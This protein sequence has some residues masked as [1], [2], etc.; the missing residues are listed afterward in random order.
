[1]CLV[2]IH[3]K[4]INFST[5]QIYF[6]IQQLFKII[7]IIISKSSTQHSFVNATLH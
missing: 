3:I 2:A 5:S 1:M 4:S 6:T 7:S